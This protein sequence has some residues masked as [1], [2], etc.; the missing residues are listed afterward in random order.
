MKSED[1]PFYGD[2]IMRALQ[3]AR[4][5]EVAGFRNRPGAV[6]HG[7]VTSS[8][9]P[10]AF[11]WDD[12]RAAMRREG[13][14]QIRGATPEV[15]LKAEHELAGFAPKQHFWD[16]F[17]ADADRVRAAC[18]QIVAG[19]LPD[20]ITRHPDDEIDATVL[21]EMQGFLTEHGIAPFSK[22][23]LSGALV[24][25]RPVILR[26][27][28][29]AIAATGYAALV[30]N[31]HSWLAGMAFVGLIAVDPAARGLGLGKMADAIA[32]LIAVDE[33]GAAGA[34]EFVA[35]DNAAS[36]AVLRACGL[37]QV[38]DRMVV[39]F[40]ASDIRITR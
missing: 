6:V 25:A 27:A 34:V 9:D 12:L 40:S 5:G 33:L 36:R 18:G 21:H 26:S 11:G 3:A 2:D 30:H 22:P 1:D 38:A 29:G 39:N 32:N 28:D 15:I 4:D 35:A 14:V 24:P 10:D 31:E 20:G 7:R 23:A 17:L 19:G 37:E 8:D 13:I 16:V